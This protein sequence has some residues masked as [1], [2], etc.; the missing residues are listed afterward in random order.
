MLI[1]SIS[2]IIFNYG[3]VGEVCNTYKAPIYTEWVLLLTQQAGTIYTGT[4]AKWMG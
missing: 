2:L 1:L 4:N 3:Y